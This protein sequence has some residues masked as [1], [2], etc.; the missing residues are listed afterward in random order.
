MGMYLSD[1]PRLRPRC[2]LQVYYVRMLERLVVYTVSTPPLL[3]ISK[4]VTSRIWF[5]CLVIDLSTLDLEF[6]YSYFSCCSE[7]FDGTLSSKEIRDQARRANKSEGP[8]SSCHFG[9][10]EYIQT[11]YLGRKMGYRERSMKFRVTRGVLLGQE[12]MW[13]QT[14]PNL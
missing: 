13:F 12:I 11:E 14:C 4:Y 5:E 2:W 1:S 9:W 3:W 6:V 7:S 10:E 8:Q